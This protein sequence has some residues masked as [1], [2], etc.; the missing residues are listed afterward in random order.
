MSKTK[1]PAN[2]ALLTASEQFLLNFAHICP[3]LVVKRS[4]LSSSLPI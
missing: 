3:I 4:N 2:M 1:H